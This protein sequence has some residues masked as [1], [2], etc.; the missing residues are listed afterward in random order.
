MPPIIILGLV[1]L[2]EALIS[3]N[4]IKVISFILNPL[5]Q[6]L[7]LISKMTN[8]NFYI[9]TPN[10]IETFFY[11]SG[12]LIFYLIYNLYNSKQQTTFKF[13]IRNIL[14]LI[15]YK[16]KNNFFKA[17]MTVLLICMLF[18]IFSIIPQD[19]KIYF[20]D[21]GQGD[22]TLIVTPKKRSILIDGGGSA[23]TSF[24]VGKNT[25]LPY[26]LDRKITKIDYMLISHFDNDHIRPGYLL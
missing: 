5:L 24:D 20:I 12:I 6:I 26:L 18:L 4:F 3:T 25:L 22:S 9:G 15:R 19:L 17:L 1:T 10:L 7:V 13:R 23:N 8:F 2:T 21:V 16:I 14:S 11:Y